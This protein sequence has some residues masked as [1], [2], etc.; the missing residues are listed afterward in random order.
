V[1]LVAIM[2]KRNVGQFFALLGFLLLVLYFATSQ[3]DSP[4]VYYFCFGVIL[5]L[6]G[7][8]LMWIGRNPP[9]GSERF[10]SLRRMSEKRNHTK[11]DAEKKPE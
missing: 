11:N 1:L 6:I 7:V 4:I 10:R 5:L 8:Y 3:V 2:W 9:V